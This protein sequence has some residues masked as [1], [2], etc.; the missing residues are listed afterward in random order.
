MTMLLQD[1]FLCNQ[2]GTHFY[3]IVI[4]RSPLIWAS[5]CYNVSRKNFEF[6]LD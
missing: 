6:D 1:M 3:V 5:L 4:L 2:F